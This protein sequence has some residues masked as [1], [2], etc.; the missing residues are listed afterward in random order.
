MIDVPHFAYPF[1]YLY[2]SPVV[3]EQDSSADVA[4]CVAAI[5]SCPLGHRIE[6]PDFGLADQALRENGANT[7]EINAA[8]AKWEPRAKSTAEHVIST[9]E[10]IDHIRIASEAPNND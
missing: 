3:N 1:R 8:L 5:L 2:G 9:D 4:D 10:L 7:A 6:Q